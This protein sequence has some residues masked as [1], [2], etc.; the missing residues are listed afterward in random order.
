VVKFLKFKQL[1]VRSF[2]K[3]GQ[4]EPSP[5]EGG[6]SADGTAGAALR[7]RRLFPDK[8]RGPQKAVAAGNWYAALLKEVLRKPVPALI[9][10]AALSVFGLALLS[11]RPAAF[12]SSGG[13]QELRLTLDFPAGT[14]LES[15]ESETAAAAR[16]VAGLPGIA[17]VFGRAGAEDE[18][19]GKR[20]DPD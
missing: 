10:A 20:A 4:A 12:V 3:P 15:M 6:T 1:E 14:T 9:L 5:A 19:T 8:P 13:V 2:K 17:A 11:R 16:N 7:T 18:D